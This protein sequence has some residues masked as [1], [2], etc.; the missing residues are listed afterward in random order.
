MRKC[1]I[2][3]SKSA[4]FHLMGWSSIPSIFWKRHNFIILYGWIK[5]CV[6]QERLNFTFILF[7]F[8]YTSVLPAGVSVH[9]IHGWYLLKSTSGVR[10]PGTGIP[11]SCEPPFGYWDSNLGRLEKCSY[12]LSYLLDLR[13]WDVLG[14]LCGYLLLRIFGFCFILPGD[15]M[16]P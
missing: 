15:E 8:M 7:Y 4:L 6:W 5:L 10:S 12:A 16:K 11:D 9:Q 1:D 2:C 14:S 13:I 3:F